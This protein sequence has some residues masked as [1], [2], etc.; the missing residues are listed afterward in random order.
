M[1][2]D[3]R[4]SRRVGYALSLKWILRSVWLQRRGNIWAQP[5]MRRPPHPVILQVVARF[6][7]MSVVQR[8][9]K[10]LHACFVQ[11]HMAGRA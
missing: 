1:F 8:L 11:V 5:W 7:K 3:T 9:K 10:C 2:S 6:T 4:D